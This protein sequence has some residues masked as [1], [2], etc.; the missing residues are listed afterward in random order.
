MCYPK[1]WRLQMRLAKGYVMAA[2]FAAGFLALCL[3]AFFSPA[4]SRVFVIWKSQ[5]WFYFIFYTPQYVAKH[6]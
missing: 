6:I 1:N 2:F 5:K 3:A 4:E